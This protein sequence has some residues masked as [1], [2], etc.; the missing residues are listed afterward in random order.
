M[1]ENSS[2]MDGN[3][4]TRPPKTAEA[5]ATELAR[6]QRETETQAR[7]LA[8][9]RWEI[10]AMMRTQSGRSRLTQL[11][12]GVL[13]RFPALSKRAS[14]VMQRTRN[15]AGTI[16]QLGATWSEPRRPTQRRRTL[17]VDQ[18]EIGKRFVAIGEPGEVTVVIPGA[19]PTRSLTVPQSGEPPLR[20]PLKGSLADWLVEEPGR[21][22]GFDTV[23]V[24]AGDDVSLALLRGRLTA[25]QHLVLTHA[26]GVTSPLVAEL[27]AP[28]SNGSGVSTYTQLPVSW[29]DPL[30]EARRP[31]PAVS[32]PQHWPKISVVMVSFNQVGFLEEGIRSVLDQR[33]P[34]LEFIVID[35]KSTDG[36]IDI[37]EKYRSRLSY[38]LIEKDKGQSEGLNKGFA[39]ATGEILT[40]L[41]SDDLLEPGA[42]FRV[43][44]AFEGRGV[45][46][47]VGGCRQIGLRRN[48]VVRNHHT[49]LPFG[50]PVALPLGLLL[51]MER[52]WL[53][54]SFFYQ[55]EV[56]FSR[57]I[58]IRSG[59]RLR[60][61]LHYVLDYDL[62]VRMAAANAT[63]VH[64]P[65]F[66]ACSRT[67]DQ[68]KTTSGMPYLP[69]VQRLLKEYAER[70][71]PPSI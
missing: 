50:P 24:E 18:S 34:N 69:E 32:T 17:L 19:G 60:T 51:E 36:S 47:V 39:R 16:R 6:L 22:R 56:F 44:Q 5:V 48:D 25:N 66:L 35:A 14:H 13:R 58:W 49:K 2:M 10:A 61:D 26:T 57:D 28:A 30:D 9:L 7:E 29:L 40:W 37:L 1:S 4:R 27:A 62:W 45:D 55:P 71:L 59:S 33:Y 42:L 41:N 43:A 52:F 8:I 11:K 23:V 68:Q 31:N 64:I 53:T 3:A 70:L 54:A 65:D 38:L 63:I 12:Y 67:H 46:M 15:L 20:E 21:L